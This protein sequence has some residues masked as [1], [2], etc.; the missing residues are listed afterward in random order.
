M[1]VTIHFEGKLKTDNDFE[2]VVK[3][4]C[5]F[6]R[7]N[8][9]DYQVFEEQNKLLQRVKNEMDWD[10]QGLTRGVKI[11]PDINADPL[12]IEFDEDYYLQEYCKTQFVDK[13]IHIKIIELLKAIEPY[14]QSLIVVDEGEYWDSDNSTLLQERLDDCF[15]AIEDAKKENTK[16]SGPFRIT[17]GRIID[18]MEND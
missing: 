7:S 9:M 5:D 14:F 2:K 16:L 4:S 3:I 1:G 11:Q 12:W 15:N 10:Y 13:S 17:G 8:D 6:A 18:L